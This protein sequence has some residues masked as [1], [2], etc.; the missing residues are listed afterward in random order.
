MCKEP[1]ELMNKQVKLIQSQIKDEVPLQHAK[2][3]CCC[4]KLVNWQYMYRCLYCGIFYCMEC[5]EQHFGK[6]REQYRLDKELIK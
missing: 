3:R 1:W 5:A 4:L 6:T 2:I